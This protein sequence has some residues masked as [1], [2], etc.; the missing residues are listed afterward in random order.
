MIRYNEGDSIRCKLRRGVERKEVALLCVFPFSV[1][2]SRTTR[3]MT[4]LKLAGRD[5]RLDNKL[6]E[7]L[8]QVCGY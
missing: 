8:Y 3:I 4:C 6:T 1:N 2:A 5:F 7:Y